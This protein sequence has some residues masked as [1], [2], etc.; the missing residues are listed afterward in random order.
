V[1]LK[2][3]GKVETI[4]DIKQEKVLVGSLMTDRFIPTFPRGVPVKEFCESINI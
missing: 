1:N 4:R 2:A 3:I